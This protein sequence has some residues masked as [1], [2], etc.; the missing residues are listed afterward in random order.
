MTHDMKV[1]RDMELEALRQSDR[2]NFQDSMR[3]LRKA[4]DLGATLLVSLLMNIISVIGFIGISV[5][6]DRNG[7]GVKVVSTITFGFLGLLVTGRLVKLFT[8][9]IK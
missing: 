5:T 2:N 6:D 4:Y 9:D 1:Y 7:L 3:N 8:H